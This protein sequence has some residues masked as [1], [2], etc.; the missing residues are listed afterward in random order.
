MWNLFRAGGV[1]RLVE[2]LSKGPMKKRSRSQV[3]VLGAG[4]SYG[5]R[6][7]YRPPLGAELAQ[8]LLSW[9]SLN[10]SDNLVPDDEIEMLNPRST[11]MPGRL[12]RPDER[13][14]YEDLRLLLERAVKPMVDGTTGFENEMNRLVEENRVELVRLLH[15]I[16][17]WS[18][19]TGR[20]CH[21]REESD[22]YGQ[23]LA[24]KTMRSLGA[25]ITLNYDTLLEEAL[26]RVGIEYYYPGLEECRGVPL[27][28]LHGSINTT[29]PSFAWALQAFRSAGNA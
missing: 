26:G 23:L 10:D 3:L 8:Y 27:Y 5:A 11:A 1:S 22:L 17:T 13:Q 28:K 9:L 7:A 25:I 16:M 12:W 24:K 29:D 21:F 18:M 4:A 19:L 15:R 20:G 2:A 14:H 6:E